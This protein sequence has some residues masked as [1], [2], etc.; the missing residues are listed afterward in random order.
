M[1]GTTE[2]DHPLRCPNCSS[3]NAESSSFCIFC[4]HALEAEEAD[5]PLEE[6]SPS[7]LQSAVRE[8]RS[9]VRQ[10]R[11]ILSSYG[12]GRSSGEEL[13]E[14]RERPRPAVGPSARTAAVRPSSAVPSARAAAAGPSPEATSAGAPG[15]P[16]QPPTS[17]PSRR[18]QMD[19]ELILGGN[20][21]A[22]I[23][24]LAVVIGVGFFLKLAFDNNWIGETGRVALGIVGGLALLGAGEYWFRRYPVYSQALTGGGIAILYLSIF[25]AFAFYSL[26]GTYP[27]IGLL[28]L[29]SVA[30]AAIALRQNSMALAAIGIVG[31]F[32]APWV[33]GEAGEGAQTELR[34]YANIELMLYVIMV[35]LGVLALSTFRNWRWFTLLGLAGSLL[36]FGVWLE[37]EG[38]E[39]N[40]A[41]AEGSLTAMFLIFVGATMLY[42]VIWRR[43]P[44]TFDQAL[45]I[46]NASAYFGISY[47]LMW[48]DF[49]DWM[50]A[51]TLAL[52]LFYGLIGYL[53]FR[54]G[55]EQFYLSLIALGIA[56]VYLTISVPVQ[57]G[58]P[59]V[60][61][62]WAVEGLALIWMSFKL[63]R[64]QMRVTGVG[65]FALSAAWLLTVDT[66]NALSLEL[67]PLFN[68]HMVSYGMVI[69][70][71][72]FAAYLVRRNKDRLEERE[73]KMFPALL[74]AGNVFLTVLVPIQLDGAWVSVAWSFEALAMVWLS[75]RLGLWEMRAF[76]AG[77]FA[78]L[79]ARLLVWETA[80]ELDDFR[81]IL[82]Y[83]MM[84]FTA[85]VAAM[86]LAALVVWRERRDETEWDVQCMLPILVVS[87][88]I[89]TLWVLSAE[90]IAVVDSGI[91]AA[92]GSAA[93]YT[94]SLA[95]SL[96]WAVYAS[97]GLV[98]GV[99]RRWRTVRI[100]SLGLL[101]IPILKLFLFD[102][103]ALDQGYR[104]A[105][106]LSLGGILLAGG[107]LYQR[108]G[109]AIRGFLFEERA[110]DG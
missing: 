105:A 17:A 84:A 64:W 87:A 6:P 21:L 46:I 13:R 91:I 55:R 103:F 66:P 58:G 98:V 97:V 76:S 90:V 31:A 37:Y 71:A 18:F 60:S 80:V 41:L 107:F 74:T 35:D 48:D 95:L 110:V 94:K 27:A 77:L 106:F 73:S 86:Y 30:A 3:E 72:Y 7:D 62:A 9:E 42:H 61:V 83:R 1:E 92:A 16:P 78:I 11:A 49:R 44:R 45:M 100:A 19:W 65:V 43:V 14:R 88:N 59:W 99:V 57:L 101:A 28:L 10:I 25:A 54:R 82:N 12:M 109:E 40:A 29:I 8:L 36:S 20:W 108:Y 32:S 4:G 56:L 70:A 89:L 15:V 34:A 85:G 104:V 47:G 38:P 75:Y 24:I 67:T 33:I 96:V 5:A 51:F 23:G 81:V 68:A 50:G 102:S 53:V 2:G 52:A 69:A 63:G 79:A 93:F 22:R 26:I 39:V